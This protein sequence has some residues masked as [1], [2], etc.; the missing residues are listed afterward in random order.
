MD[1]RFINPFIRSCQQHFDRQMQ[2]TLSIDRAH[3]KDA[4]T[5]LIGHGVMMTMS[6]TGQFAGSV[7]VFLDQAVAITLADRMIGTPRYRLDEAAYNALRGLANLIVADVKR[8]LPS[9][10]TR[11]SIPKVRKLT[12][13]DQKRGPGSLIVPLTC[14]AGQVQIEVRVETS[15][16]AA[17][18]APT[19]APPVIDEAEVQEMVTR[20]LNQQAA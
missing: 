15:N 17:D 10:G 14:K 8:E 11:I 3:L 2:L 1:V 5:T 18:Q 20:L 13:E 7:N 6:L 9:G 19:M 4:A 16:V 12:R